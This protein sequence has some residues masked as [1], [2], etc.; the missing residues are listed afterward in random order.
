[1]CGI[2][3]I[4]GQIDSQNAQHLK[5]DVESLFLLSESR[6]KEA[7]GL[8]FSNEKE[9]QVIK[10]DVPASRLIRE[11]QFADLFK[12]MIPEIGMFKFEVI[13]HSRLVTTGSEENE[14]N[15][16]PVIK[17]RNVVIHNGI[18]T[19]FE[20]LFSENTDLEK[21]YEVDT[22]IIPSLFSA[23][24][25]KG[26]TVAKS[27]SSVFRQIEGTASVC[28]ISADFELC[29]LATNNGSLYYN[30]DENLIVF[31]SERYILQKYI[32]KSRIIKKSNIKQL[33]SNNCLIYDGDLI[34]LKEIELGKYE[35]Y[36]ALLKARKSEIF[37]HSDN[38]IG[39]KKGSDIGILK[40]DCFEDVSQQ[41][42][43]LVRCKKCILP[44]TFP[45][46]EFNE[47]G[48][49]NYC[50]NY[51]SKF[52]KDVNELKER[53]NY[54]L[55]Y[56][57]NFRKKNS[58]DVLVP[59]SGGRD[60]SFGLDYIKN[61]LKLNPVTFTYD[62][63]MIT[64]LARRNIARICGKLGIENILVSADIRRKREYIR[65]NVAAWLRKPELGMIPLFMAG[66]KQFFRIVNVLKKQNN[67]DL[68]IWM[69][70]PLENTDFKTGFAGIRPNFTKER[71]YDL[72]TAEKVKLVTYYLKNFVTNFSYLN[73]SIPDTVSAF[74]S[75][76]KS[77]R[78]DYVHLFKYL[79]WDEDKIE[80]YL[81][82]E[83][84]WEL[85]TDTKSS[86][87]IGDGTA[88]FYNYIYNTV[89]GFT[90]NDTFRS[91]QIREGMI[92]RETALEKVIEENNPRYESLKWYFDV[93]KLD[94]SD[95]IRKINFMQK[96]F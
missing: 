65:K 90:E 3:G 92:T 89:A 64:D 77:E 56:V 76:Y 35:E 84:N 18:I 69:T 63:G 16:Q 82:S 91:N 49:C 42:S 24:M 31:S 27:I 34:N 93:L 86:W 44:E 30:V 13:G 55:N 88:A 25:A 5:K 9:I 8:A 85:A 87:R 38:I 48:I 61:N 83:Y 66:D 14:Y 4:I 95:A 72:S 43:K 50:L 39:N 80:N 51:K 67:I 59:F 79:Y 52:T 6:G 12:K 53:E 60:S 11:K 22:E 41:I 62:W 7:S 21:Q 75:Y 40:K 81:V 15:N 19:N 47:D 33:I 57:N 70:N 54:L 26:M 45:F 74:F 37:V 17:N 68:N 36:S 1:M 71:I 10:K 58:Y 23:N 96:L 28:L 78:K 94:Y 46:I 32:S 29:I 2:F 73:S 20:K